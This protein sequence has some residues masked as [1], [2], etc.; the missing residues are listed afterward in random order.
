MVAF[1]V[2]VVSW[3]SQGAYKKE[4]HLVTLFITVRCYILR[5]AIGHHLELKE[6]K[7]LCG[8]N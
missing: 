8:S 1:F 5:Y 4:F 6:V 2:F 7:L 3:G